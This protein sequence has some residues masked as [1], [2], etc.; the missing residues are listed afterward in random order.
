MGQPGGTRAILIARRSKLTAGIFAGQQEQRGGEN[1]SG[2]EQPRLKTP[3]SVKVPSLRVPVVTS[4]KGPLSRQTTPH[5][6]HRA[7]TGDG[8]GV[9]VRGDDDEPNEEAEDVGPADFVED[10]EADARA[11]AAP[12][13]PAP[14]ELSHSATPVGSSS[15]SMKKKKTS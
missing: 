9:F 2:D 15:S 14:V 6:T 11:D 7:A 13:P 4:P 10:Y 12:A 8:N 1:S 3:S 5:S